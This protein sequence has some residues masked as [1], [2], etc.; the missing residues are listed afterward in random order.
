MGYRS[1]NVIQTVPFESLGVIFYSP[2]IVAMTLSCII[3]EISEI[4]VEKC[5]F[6]IPLAFDAIAT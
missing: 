3:C 4:L 1:L 2:S 5:D 6:F